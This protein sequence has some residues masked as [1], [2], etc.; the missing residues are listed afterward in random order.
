M[1]LGLQLLVG[2]LVLGAL[3]A[4]VALGFALILNVTRTFHF[5]H[6]ATYVAGAYMAYALI[7]QLGLHWLPAVVLAA[8]GT[9]VLGVAVELLIYQP[10][11]NRGASPM[12]IVVAS[13]GA[14]IVIQS[15]V[16]VIWRSDIRT[17]NIG[18]TGS[19]AQISGVA[20]TSSAVAA[21]LVGLGSCGCVWL[22]LAKT[23]MGLSIRAVAS[24][25][26]RAQIVGIPSR[27]VR[28]VTFAIASALV[29][30]IGVVAA[31]DQGLQPSVGEGAVL[32]AGIATIVGGTRNVFGSILGSF[33]IGIIESVGIWQVSSAWQAAIGF[34]VLVLFILWRPVGLLGKT[35]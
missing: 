31:I 8:L 23:R 22:L 27:T 20:I 33:L 21:I 35:V 11:R 4:P 16:Q 32:Y 1:T 24:N 18:V 17:L 28:I 13:L 25:P 14:L 15:A 9:C 10:M 19:V 30:P 5:A 7:V 2:G 29:V 3:Y 12:G 26:V 6:G 34:G